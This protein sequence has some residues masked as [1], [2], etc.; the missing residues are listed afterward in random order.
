MF[1]LRD[2]YS[3]K[4]VKESLLLT[5]ELYNLASWLDRDAENEDS[6]ETAETLMKEIEGA[7]RLNLPT[8]TGNDTSK[9]K[10]NRSSQQGEGDTPEPNSKR[11][12]MD[13]TQV[14]EAHGYEVEPE[15]WVDE[16]GGTW[17]VIGKVRCKG[18]STKRY[19]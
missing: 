7:K 4:N 15:S 5:R 10:R 12:R 19:P 3:L 1:Y 17:E 18:R 2:E 16:S 9:G 8:F 11:Q 14:L 13:D 6:K